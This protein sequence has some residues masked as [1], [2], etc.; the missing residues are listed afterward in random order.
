[1]Y[2]LQSLRYSTEDPPKN[3]YIYIYMY[4]YI[5]KYIYIYTYIYVYTR[6]FTYI[7]AVIRRNTHTNHTYK[8]CDAPS[9]IPTKIYSLYNYIFINIGIREIIGPVLVI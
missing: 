6:L 5:Y 1:M 9:G 7:Q 2:Y 4:I 3:I 8:A